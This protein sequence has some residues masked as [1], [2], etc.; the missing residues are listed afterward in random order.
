METYTP[1]V[2]DIAH[3]VLPRDLAPLGEMLAQQDHE[4]WATGRMAEGWTYGPHRDDHAKHHPCL[5]PYEELP[6]SEKDYNRR[7]ALG[8][9]KLILALGFRIESDHEEPPH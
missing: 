1:H 9:L 2:V 6:E 3:I 5:V 8:T 7:G 4:R